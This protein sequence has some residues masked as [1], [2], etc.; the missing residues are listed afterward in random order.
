MNKLLKIT[1][2]FF[3]FGKFNG[4]FTRF[5]VPYL[6]L[7]TPKPKTNKPKS[8]S[9]WGIGNYFWN[10]LNL[11]RTIFVWINSIILLLNTWKWWC[12]ISFLLMTW[13]KKQND[14]ACH[15][16]IRLVIFFNFMFK[17]ILDLNFLFS[18][19]S[20]FFFFSL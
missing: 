8:L 20:I 10:A 3:F 19:S 4:R 12:D 6:S 16:I 2:D 17:L 9:F 13:K 14:V 18:F 11:T 5:F 15:N 1:I 7:P